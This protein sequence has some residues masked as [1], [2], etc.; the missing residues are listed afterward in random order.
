MSIANAKFTAGGSSGQ[1]QLAS[2]SIYG[3]FVEPGGTAP[4]SQQPSQSLGQSSSIHHFPMNNFM[5]SNLTSALFS[6]AMGM[7]SHQNHQNHPRTSEYSYDINLSAVNKS[8]N[9]YNLGAAQ[10]DSQP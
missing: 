4:S 6:Q 7:M 1:G 3:G 2:K 10:M 5:P 8:L 9:E